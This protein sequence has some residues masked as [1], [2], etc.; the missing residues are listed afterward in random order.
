M[1]NQ[2][3]PPKGPEPE[4]PSWQIGPD[5]RVYINDGGHHQGL[6]GVV[7]VA[8]L[9]HVAGLPGWA[10]V[11]LDRYDRCVAVDTRYLVR[12]IPDSVSVVLTNVAPGTVDKLTARIGEVLMPGRGRVPNLDFRRVRV[13]VLPGNVL[14]GGT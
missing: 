10:K 8:D 4:A 5:T 11:R 13:D 14:K 7:I 9:G 6:Q 1:Q 12:E 2:T 3:Q